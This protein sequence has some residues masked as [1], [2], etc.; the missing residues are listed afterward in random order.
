MLRILETQ[1]VCNLTHILPC[2]EYLFF[3]KVYNLVLNIF[4]RSLSGFFF[5]RSPK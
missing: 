5:I 2:P 1:L 3:R 4:L